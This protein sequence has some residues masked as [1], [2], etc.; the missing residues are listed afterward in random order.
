MLALALGVALRVMGYFGD[1]L[2]L[3]LDEASWAVMLVDG[4]FTWIRPAGYM[5]LTG[6]LVSIANNEQ[7][8][9]ALS[10]VSGIALLPLWLFVLR[11]TVQSKA[12]VVFGLVLLAIQPVA[13]GMSKEFKP[14]ILEAMLH[15]ALIAWTLA[16]L[17][18]RRR[19]HMI[20]LSTTALV[21]P[22]FAWSVVFAYPAVFA[23]TCWRALRDRRFADMAIG[24]GGAFA[25]LAALG[26]I[27]VMR[28]AGEDEKTDFWGRKYD[29]FFVDSGL[30]AHLEWLVAKTVEIQQ[31]PATLEL[32]VPLPGLA[33]ALDVLAVAFG[34]AGVVTLLARRRFADA[35]VWLLPWAV[36]L[37]F[38]IAGKW[39]WGVFRTNVFML[40]YATGILCIGLDGIGRLTT[41]LATRRWPGTEVRVRHLGA[42]ALGVT[43]LLIFPW[44]LSSFHVK[45]QDTLTNSTSVRTAMETIYRAEHAS[46]AGPMRE[47]LLDGH[48]CG[49][50]EYYA[51]YHDET[52]GTL[53]TFFRERYLPTCD[54]FRLQTWE[55]MLA[56][57]ANKISWVITAKPSFAAPTRELLRQACGATLAEEMPVGTMLVRCAPSVVGVESP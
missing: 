24:V 13:I 23:V 6:V 54:G 1:A 9:R 32:A 57:K 19:G 21:A 55:E 43:A 5:W 8:L 28:L 51:G 31:A 4:D 11:R 12:V 47:L 7:T 17:K 39:P 18:S 53:G 56:A 3:W 35:V 44:D 26:G 42:I 29:V 50:F 37:T 40:L 10:L 52:K 45:K 2:Q 48:A 30:G 16:Y 41:L 34:L 33:E 38:N 25:T 20:G 14:Y 46:P 27:W 36:A 49:I 15:G 22:L